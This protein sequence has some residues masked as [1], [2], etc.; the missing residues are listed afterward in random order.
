[1]GFPLEKLSCR[2]CS[3]LDKRDMCDLQGRTMKEPGNHYCVQI[4]EHFK[5][6]GFRAKMPPPISV[7]FETIEKEC[8]ELLTKFD[9]WSKEYVSPTRGVFK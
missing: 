8:K 1:M 5:D 7:D 3:R 2:N 9:K 6:S 4:F